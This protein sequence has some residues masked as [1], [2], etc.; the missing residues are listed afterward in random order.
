LEGGKRKQRAADLLLKKIQRAREGK[1]TLTL[2]LKD[3]FGNS[4]IIS[5][6]AKKPGISVRELKGLKLSEQVIAARKM[7]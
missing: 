4:T 1:L 7:Q 3:P 5:R 6:K 2:M